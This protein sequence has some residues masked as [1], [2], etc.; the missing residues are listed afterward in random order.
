MEM[1]FGSL[2]PLFA[3]LTLVT[4]IT[5]NNE[6]LHVSPLL[7]HSAF[8]QREEVW[9]PADTAPGHFSHWGRPI[10]SQKGTPGRNWLVCDH[11]SE[12]SRL[13]GSR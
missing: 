2:H 12:D 8:I 11:S 10:Q 3:L 5:E 6:L 7:Q 9:D 1:L 13:V 4:T